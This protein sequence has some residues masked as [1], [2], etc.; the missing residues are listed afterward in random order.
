MAELKRFK[1]FDV[2]TG[3]LLVE[4]TAKECAEGVGLSESGFRQ[5]AVISDGVGHSKYKIIDETPPE[6]EIRELSYD[7]KVAAKKWDEFCEPIRKKYGIPVYK[8]PAKEDNS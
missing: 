7:F 5:A 6:D 1:V 8:E 4:G 2:K 3:E